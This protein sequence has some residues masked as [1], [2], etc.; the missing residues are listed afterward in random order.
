[1]L[2]KSRFAATLVATL[3]FFTGIAVFIWQ[4]SGSK[5][6]NYPRVEATIANEKFTLLA[7]QTTKERQRGLSAVA[8]LPSGYGMLFPGH[9]Y[10]RI[11][12]KDMKY[13]IDIVW[14][15]KDGKVIHIV[16]NARPSS[17][18]KTTFVNPENTAAKYAI[19]LNSGEAK[20]LGLG[21]TSTIDMALS[22]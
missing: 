17:Y 19:E 13:P 15:D 9:K 10:I 14:I 1:M 8:K 16:D 5:L 6:P 18:P 22:K 2:T 12:M 7:P 21:S 20:R 11:W 3:V 4:L